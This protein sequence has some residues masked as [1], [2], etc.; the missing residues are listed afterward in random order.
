MSEYK[1][2]EDRFDKLDTVLDKIDDRLNSIDITL[3]KQSTSLQE[4]IRR[5][6]LAEEN[7]ELLRTEIKPLSQH[8]VTINSLAKIISV[9]AAIAVIARLFLE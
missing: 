4:H 6:E 1:R 7:I 5:T 8:V 3:A 9:L 2:I